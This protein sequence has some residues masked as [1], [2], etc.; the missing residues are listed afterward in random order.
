MQQDGKQKAYPI[1]VIDDSSNCV[2]VIYALVLVKSWQ[3]AQAADQLKKCLSDDGIA[4][5]M[6][7][8]L[9]NREI[10]ESVL[11]EKRVALGVTTTGAT[12]LSSGRVRPGGEGMISLSEHARLKPIKDYLEL[13]NFNLEMIKDIDTLIWSKMVVNA[14]INPITALLQVSNGTLLSRASARQLSSDLA[15]EVAEVALAQGIKLSFKDPVA[16]A[17][18]IERTVRKYR[19]ASSAT[20]R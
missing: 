4:L 11:G 18:L 8:G 6:Q 12:L 3:T 20:P 2:D 9:G 13:A 17:D 10:L 16:A 19:R 14:A 7:N 1:T 5:T 15:N